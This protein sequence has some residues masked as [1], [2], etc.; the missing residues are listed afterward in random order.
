MIIPVF[1]RS[2]MIAR[3]HSSHLGVDASIRRARDVSFWPGMAG[4]IKETV[5]TC[6]VS[7][8]FLARQQKET[9]MTHKL[10]DTPWSKVAL[11]IFAL[12]NR[13]I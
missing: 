2:P 12:G 4:Q 11:D 3:V 10:P 9:L 1:M 6:E 8:D 7:N 5:Y 13:T